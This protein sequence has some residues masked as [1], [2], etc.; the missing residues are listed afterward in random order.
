MLGHR[1]LRSFA[2][3][4]FSCVVCLVILAWPASLHGQENYTGKRI[5][6]LY[7]DN[8]DFPGNQKFEES[9]KAALQSQIAGGL[10]YYPEYFE[11]TRFP[12]QDQAFFRDYLR[13]KYRDRNMDVLVAT[14]DAP[15]NFLVAN[16]AD[17][18]PNTPIVFVANDPPGA[19]KLFAG[20]GITGLIHQTTHRQTLELALKLHPNTQQVFVISGSPERDK[21]FETTARRELTGFENRVQITYLTD[22]P[23]NELVSKTASLPPNSIAL[24]IWQQALNE[25][26]KILETFE[27]IARIS[28][29]SSVPIYGLGTTNLGNGIVGGYL[30][31]ALNNGR[32]VGEISVRIL[33]GTPARD[34]PVEG[35][36]SISM[37]DARELNR[38]GIDESRLP[39]G[40]II[41]FRQVTFWDRYKWSIILILTAFL[42]ETAL[43]A[44]LLFTQ[45][46]R[47]QAEEETERLNQ[48]SR[49]AHRRL[50]EIVSNVPGVVWESVIDPQTK[51]RRTT[52]IS[53][54]V[55]TVLGYS[56]DEWLA[57]PPGF[58]MRI[59][60]EED[61]ERASAATKA[62]ITKGT[63]TVCQF[64]W[65][66]RDGRIVWV[67]SYLSPVLS[68]SGATKGLR[69]VTLDIT[70]RKLAEEAVRKAEEK[71]R[72]IVE[73][74]PDLMFLQT[75]DGVYLDL[76]Y[77]DPDNL[78][79]PPREYLGKNMRE[80]LPPELA[81]RFSHYFQ[82]AIETRETQIVEY[83]LTLQGE[84]RWY[85]SRLVCC[86]ENILSV[87][88]DITERRKAELALSESER[89]LRLAQQAA[90]VGTWEWDM[91]TGEAVWSEMMWELLGLNPDNSP[92]RLEEFAEVI[93][94][95]DRERTLANIEQVI[96]NDDE[97]YDEFRILQPAG[98]V[99]WM[100][101]QGRVLRGPDGTPERMIGVNV[102]ITKRRAAEEAAR[103][104]QQKDAA[105][106]NAIPDLMFL[107]SRDG[108][109]LDYHANSVEDLFVP[110]AAFMG[111]SM[112]DVLPP[113]LA[114][115][116]IDC[117]ARLEHTP[118][119]QVVEYSL[120]MD[121]TE[122]WYECRLVRSGE[123]VL[124]VVR[125]ITEQRNALYEQRQSDEKFAKAFRANPQP[126][127]LTTLAEGRFLDVNPAFLA[128]TGY[129]RDEVIGKT[130]VELGIWETPGFR[131]DF[132]QSLR[133][134]GAITNLEASVRAKDGAL[135]LLLMS[136]EQIELGG[137]KCVLVAS[138]DI[139]ERKRAEEALHASEEKY[140]TLFESIDEGFCVFDLIYDEGGRAVD[141]VFRVTNPAFERQTGWHNVVDKR[142]RE[143]A[144]DL[145]EYWFE[146]YAQVAATKTPVRFMDWA[147]ALNRWYEVYAFP[148]GEA[149]SRTVAVIFSDVSERVRAEHTLQESEARFRNM[150]DTAPVLIWIS[151]TDNRVTYV[152]QQWLDFTGRTA[153]QELGQGWTEGIHPDDLE[154]CLATYADAS[155]RREPFKLEYQLRRADG[156]HRW[157]FDTGT[158]RFSATGKF[159]GY[160]GSCV[161]ITTR[162][163][164]EQALLEAHEQLVIAHKEV[165]RLKNELEAEN[166][167][168]REELRAD[169]MFGEMV[170][171]SDAIKYVS[172]KV[173]QVAVTDSTVLITGET[174]TG[175]EL[176]AHA[177]HAASLRSERP[178]ITVNCAALPASLIESE[179][180]GH[181]RGAFTGA[182]ARKL[183]R[184]ELANGGTIFLDE[185]G[186]LPL[187]SQV[188]L[189]RVLQEGEIERLGGAKAIKV[190]VRIIAATNRNLKHEIEKGT[191]R[192]D[193]WY[194]LNVFPITVPPLRQRQE[195]IPLLV[196]HFVSHYA[197]KF[198]KRITSI[199]PTSMQKL[200]AYTW[201]GN[202]RELANVIERAVIY[203]QGDV[204]HVVDLAESAREQAPSAIKSLEQIE[205]EYILRILEQTG[206][207]I[208]G[209]HGAA[210]LLGLN[211]ST[212]R[213]RMIKLGIH[214]QTLTASN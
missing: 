124:S 148:V 11:T 213:T 82:R 179:L 161:D 181:E 105:I 191:F 193:L 212:L 57:E 201:P 30:T 15:L 54:H 64:R 60:V 33:N 166:I 88:R 45:S 185:I 83:E 128:V 10:E 171:E 158:P 123:N 211:P 129:R 141:F 194:R 159:L 176:V 55:R 61:R 202:V 7:W 121:G 78:I 136:A 204:L 169:Q 162:K 117:F 96:Q 199:S 195:D 149:G 170:G 175:K 190:D 34:I 107:Q 84:H 24:Y 22:L 205:R 37:F 188:K 4:L 207:R 27:V 130:A 116:L 47:R 127:T 39:A 21:R 93:H 36:P 137:Q 177:I 209:P 44:R 172:F 104:T 106:L 29:S 8:K 76:H 180:F 58:G 206:W 92:M 63:D 119:P 197:K 74:I 81:E 168:L 108:V 79:V 69:G 6:V 91:G 126:M 139:T 16:R 110:P 65:R 103:Q 154:R 174:G 20:P 142:V 67:E 89:R 138:T 52:F 152:N 150:A 122:K 182:A 112:R 28:P 120:P 183:G 189:L 131:T 167:Y 100:S 140:R 186:E 17:L 97:Y 184:F 72:A 113:D 163:E 147:G 68:E 25:Q 3:T 77:E 40:S 98:K 133:E 192:E 101:V 26:G 14:A 53:D 19:D 43:V 56:P 151:D 210:K 90:R 187:E 102:D 32:K 196:E 46:K 85:E 86:G 144:P 165:S 59:M 73:V 38:W 203:T 157:I 125:D 135:R 214:K 153:D 50:Q 18:F 75:R 134:D 109:F 41:S 132:I 155:N 178:F 42:A 146:K 94:P 12:G 156:E 48:L 208:E 31:G 23:L 143:L 145:E 115:K 62:A 80:I 99:V 1:Q 111:K 164:S 200:S 160:I 118:E 9:F 5:L 2:L 71:D 114:K 49:Q 35:A 66:A 51:E 13:Q 95:E 173:N 70:Q 87:V 198:G